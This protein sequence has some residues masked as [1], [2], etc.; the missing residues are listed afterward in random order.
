MPELTEEQAA[1][2]QHYTEYLAERQAI[3]QH[4]ATL[5]ATAATEA[6]FDTALLHWVRHERPTWRKLRS[7]NRDS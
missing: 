1:R 2:A 4:Q 5:T 3:L 6:N 7:K